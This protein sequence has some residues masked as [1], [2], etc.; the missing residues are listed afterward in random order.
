MCV[1]V[2]ERER[3][4]C[5]YAYVPPPPP[6]PR[7]RLPVLNGQVNVRKA[8]NNVLFVIEAA[9]PHKHH[10]Y[11]NTKPLHNVICHKMHK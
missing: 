11:I 2:C 7:V 4:V 3:G 8:C 1:C 10:A 9:V 6:P 5:V